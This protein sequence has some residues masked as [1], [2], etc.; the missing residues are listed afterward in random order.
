MGIMPTE[1]DAE[2]ASELRA[3]LAA[4]DNVRKLRAAAALLEERKSKIQGGVEWPLMHVAL[5]AAALLLE[6]GERSTS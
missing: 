6:E 5:A 1:R 3:A 4:D 2:L